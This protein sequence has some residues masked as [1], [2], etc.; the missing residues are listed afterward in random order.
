MGGEHEMMHRP[1]AA[2]VRTLRCPPPLLHGSLKPQLPQGQQTGLAPTRNKPAWLLTPF[3]HLAQKIPLL[4]PARDRR[5]ALL[6]WRVCGDYR[7]AARSQQRGSATLVLG[8]GG[9]ERG[10]RLMVV[11]GVTLHQQFLIPTAA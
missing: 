1:R 5:K 3:H 11:A 10:K 7:E 4:L 2:P 9:R 6:S 8:G